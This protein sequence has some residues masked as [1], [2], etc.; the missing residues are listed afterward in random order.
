MGLWGWM[1]RAIKKLSDAK[2]RSADQGVHQDGGGLS[3]KVKATGAKQWLFRFSLRGKR[4]DMGLGS[5]PEI[6]LADAR[7]RAEQAR[8]DVANGIDPRVARDARADPEPEAGQPV[9]FEDEAEEFLALRL[10]Q[11]SNPKHRQQWRNTLAT[12]VYPSIGHMPIDEVRAAH[13]LR[14]LQPIWRTHPETARRVLGRIENIID[15][16]TLHGRRT[17]ASP[18]VGVAAQLGKKRPAVK[19]H[20]ALPWRDVPGFL[21]ALDELASAHVSKLA[22]EFAILT[23][24]RSG[25]VRGAAWDEIDR[26]ARLWNVPPERMKM[27]RP[28]R[29]PLSN[30]ALRV[31]DR[32]ARH[33]CELQRDGRP[34][35][36]PA[37]GGTRPLT[38]MTLTMLLRR[39]SVP[40]VPH[41]FRSSFRDWA[42][43]NKIEAN[44][45]LEACLAHVEPS[46]SV[47]AYARSDLL[48]RR[49]DVMDRW[50][51]FCRP[52]NDD[53]EGK[54][55][56]ASGDE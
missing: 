53:D 25:E 29:V 5:Y 45:V 15:H 48:D 27:R 37:H 7:E 42:S 12:Y 3:L 54:L 56:E 46:K 28:H 52:A 20:P 4:S 18:T 13:V 19:H 43:E 21:A 47:R 17:L 22:L 38:D 24:S 6:G 40:A 8:R 31:L 36:F 50:G 51:A 35:V 26:A 11:L 39:M 55:S 41:G 33:H 10:P 44:E 2:V 1:S 32:A 23:A 49:R 34:L 16:A 30:A 9:T 14:L